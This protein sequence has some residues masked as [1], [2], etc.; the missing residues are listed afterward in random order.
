MLPVRYEHHL[1]V[2]SEAISAAGREGLERC[3]MLRNLHYLVSRLTD[4]RELASL[5]QWSRSTAQKHSYLC[6]WCSFLLE[7]E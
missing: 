6:L 3:N 1:H 4:G 2:D 5:M 7:A